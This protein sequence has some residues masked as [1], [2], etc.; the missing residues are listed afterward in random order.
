MAHPIDDHRTAPWWRR[1]YSISGGVLVALLV[2]GAAFGEDD[3]ADDAASAATLPAPATM[4]PTTTAMPPTTVAAP[5][6]APATT[7]VPPTT[8]PAT[9]TVPPTTVAAPAAPLLEAAAL[10]VTHVVD[11]DTVDVS[12][13]ERIR[14]IGID[15]PERGECGYE[16]AARELGSLVAGRTVTL[17]RGAQDDRDR[18]GRLLR[19]VDTSDGVD[20]GLALIEADLAI[21]RYDSRD[22]YGRHDREDAYV[23]ADD[24]TDCRPAVPPAAQAPPADGS[25]TAATAGADGGGSAAVHYANCTAAREAGAAPLHV[26]DPGYRPAMDRDNDGIACE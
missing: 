22:G 9:T 13:G 8:V 21:A 4:G 19:Y 5:P 10:T 16:Q 12:N 2:L 14:I 11:G 26:G 1:W 7:A 3:D 17:V 15:T 23:A 20:T 6:A 18:Y 24:G 25:D